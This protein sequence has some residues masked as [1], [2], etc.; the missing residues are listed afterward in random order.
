MSR[1]SLVRPLFD[2]PLDLIGDVHGEIDAL[3]NLLRKLGYSPDG[4]H[5]HGR[6]LVYLGDLTD[7]GP[8]SPAVVDLVHRQLVAGLAQC[9]LGNHDLNIL[10]DE[11]KHDNRWFSGRDSSLDR[12]GEVTPA[13]LADNAIRQRV[14]TLFQSLP[15]ALERHDLRVVHACWEPAMIDVARDADDAVRLY[16]AF[17]ERIDAE[18]ATRPECDP[19]D[20]ELAHQNGNPVKVITSGPERRAAVPFE[21]SGKFRHEER[22]PWWTGYRDEPLCVFG[23]YGIVYGQPRPQGRTVCVDYAVGKRWFERRKQ[24][25][26]GRFRGRLAAFRHP[27]R[28]MM[29]DDYSSDEPQ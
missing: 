26:N 7:R 8:D 19:V 15:L 14:R 5:P 3:Q 28:L 29:F 13:V 9:V 2:G 6:R 10:L 16:R 25:F 20:R 24:N 1:V 11:E 12:S 18:N 23:H 21:A 22:A 27:E 4:V 17:V